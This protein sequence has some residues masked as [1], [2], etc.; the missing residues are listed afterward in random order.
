MGVRHSASFASFRKITLPH[1]RRKFVWLPLLVSKGHRLQHFG[2]IIAIKPKIVRHARNL[3][4][5]ANEMCT[6]QISLS[7]DKTVRMHPTKTRAANRGPNRGP[8]P[9]NLCCALLINGFP[10][11]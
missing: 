7:L 5:K 1:T 11:R 4:G 10:P 2:L 8:I 6:R 9:A 3:E